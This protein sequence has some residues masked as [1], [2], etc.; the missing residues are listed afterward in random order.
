MFSILYCLQ[1]WNKI[2]LTSTTIRCFIDTDALL[3][4]IILGDILIK[5]AFKDINEQ[6]FFFFYNRLFS[7]LICVQNVPFEWKVLKSSW[8]LEWSNW[9]WF[10]SNLNFHLLDHLHYGDAHIH[11]CMTPSKKEFNWQKIIERFIHPQHIICDE[12]T[13]YEEAE[14][15]SGVERFWIFFPHGYYFNCKSIGKF[16]KQFCETV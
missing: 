5:I 16:S 9:M 14:Q 8:E 3:F 10:P 13:E 15:P 4:A 2:Y 11:L 12:A 7:C 1:Y 6:Q